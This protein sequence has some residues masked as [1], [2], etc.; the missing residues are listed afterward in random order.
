[1]KTKT[2]ILTAVFALFASFSA[3]AASTAEQVFNKASPSVVVI[4]AVDHTNKPIGSGSGVVI[5]KNQIVTNWHVVSGAD[6]II[7]RR[8]DT[9]YPAEVIADRRDRDLAL[10]SAKGLEAPAIN[11]ATTNS[12]SV[13]Q[14]VFAIGAPSG[15]DLTI[16]NGI[17]SALRNVEDG[18]LIQTS[19]AISPGSSGGG[20]FNEDGRLIGITTLKLSG[21]AREGLGFA[22]SADWVNEIASPDAKSGNSFSDWGW[23]VAVFVIL[24]IIAFGKRIYYKLCDGGL[25]NRNSSESSLSGNYESVGRK[26]SEVR[27][28]KKESTVPLECF[29]MAKKEIDSGNVDQTT[30][31]KAQSFSDGDPKKLEEVYLKLRANELYE[32]KKQVANVNSPQENDATELADTVA[33]SKNPLFTE[34]RFAIFIIALVSIIIFASAPWFFGKYFETNLLA[35]VDS[36]KTANAISVNTKVISYERGWLSSKF[37]LEHQFGDTDFAIKSKNSL[38]HIPTWFNGFSLKLK[39]SL[40]LP[41]DSA[42]FDANQSAVTYFYPLGGFKSSAEFSD[43]VAKPVPG[44]KNSYISLRGLKF[45]LEREATSSPLAVSAKLAGFSLEEKNKKVGM[46][47]VAFSLD[48]LGILYGTFSAN[49]KSKFTIGSALVDDSSDNTHLKVSGFDVGAQQVVSAGL[50]DFDYSISITDISYKN[51]NGLPV[52]IKNIATGVQLKN[53]NSIAFANLDNVFGGKKTRTKGEAEFVKMMPVLLSNSPTLLLKESAFTISSEDFSGSFVLKADASV[54]GAGLTPETSTIDDYIKRTKF[55]AYFSAT[56]KLLNKFF[57]NSE[58]ATRQANVKNLV[59]QGRVFSQDQISAYLAES[60]TV[61]NQQVDEVLSSKIAIQEG[62][63]LKTK[64]SFSKGEWA[65]NDVS[66]SKVVKDFIEGFKEG[67]TGSKPR[68][69]TNAN[70]QTKSLDGR[71][72]QEQVSLVKNFV[73]NKHAQ[74]TKFNPVL[75]N[76]I[77]IA[78]AYL[79]RKG[80]T[81]LPIPV[82]DSVRDKEVWWVDS[83][84]FHLYLPNVTGQTIGGLAYELDLGGDCQNRVGPFLYSLLAFDPAITSNRSGV[85]TMPTPNNLPRG[86]G[87]CGTIVSVW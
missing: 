2:S 60:A 71:S 57:E 3:F 70:E 68:N 32:I 28:I 44:S 64:I 66:D 86:K 77:S 72:Y 54:D 11:T 34:T 30:Y 47:D 17:V 85:V 56:P 36:K 12:V 40:V 19:A 9:N 6:S 52:Q 24:V 10:V 39:S 81:Q 53:L 59:A 69:M 80:I 14:N 13:G 8:K 84:G 67:S 29:S 4:I 26:S 23:L 87:M 45:D 38:S 37:S 49:A 41:E 74:H 21:D 79:Q 22:V 61:A 43:I 58:R 46:S 76:D 35:V 82:L 7:V 5:G 65:I 27:N 73:A 42:Y 1:M 75:F 25:L 51:E 33:S 31:K 55:N 20:L 62:G 18:K 63:F 15:L 16:T 48:N 78:K 83:S 50:V